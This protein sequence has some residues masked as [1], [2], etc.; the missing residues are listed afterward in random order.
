[1]GAACCQHYFLVLLLKIGSCAYFLHEPQ[2]RDSQ[3]RI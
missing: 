2:Q 3:G 1:M